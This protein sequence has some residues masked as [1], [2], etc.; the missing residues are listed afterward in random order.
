MRFETRDSITRRRVLS[1]LLPAAA[2]LA[3]SIVTGPHALAQAQAG[4]AAPNTLTAAEK[5]AGWKLLFDGKTTE[6]WR[7]YHSTTFPAEGWAVVDGTI[8]KVGKGEKPGSGGDIITTGEY[9]N[10]ELALEWK[11]APGGNSGLKY[12]I[13]ETP[14]GTGHAGVGYE[15]QILDDERH[16]DAKEGVN[17]N[18]TAGSLY[19]LI[20][21]STHAARPIGEWNQSTPRRPRPPRRALAE[22]PES[23]A[24]RDRQPRDEGSDRQEQVQGHQG[25]RRG[26]ERPHPAAGSRRRGVV[27]KH[28]ASSAHGER[29]GLI[30]RWPSSTTDSCS[31]ATRRG[32]CTNGTPPDSRCST[33]TV[34]CRR[35]ISRATGNSGICS[36]SGSKATTTSGGRCARTAFAEMYCTGD[37]SP[38]EKFKAWAATVPRCLRN[39]LYHWTHL[40][41]KRYFDIDELLDESSADRHLAAG[42][43]AAAVAGTV[44]ARDPCRSST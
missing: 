4:T 21:P 13:T 42:Q 25:L 26:D 32:A 40:E 39:P 41:L 35:P 30:A 2:A 31:T 12:L 36:R 6:G 23:R 43:R 33:I 11:L 22:R 10:F 34:T 8:K 28:Q 16:P 7:G 24:V 44:G 27:P 29:A 37:A 18:R 14:D 3:V 20:A 19:D 15:M 38:Y 1:A 9:S 5:A 17:G